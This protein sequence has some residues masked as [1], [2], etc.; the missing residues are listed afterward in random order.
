MDDIKSMDGKTANASDRTSSI[1][2]SVDKMNAMSIVSVKNNWC[3]ATEFIK[4]KPNEIPSGPELLKKIN[5]E[6]CI[7]TFDSMSTQENTINHIAA[8]HAFYVARVKGN[9]PSLEESI[10]EYFN[11]RKLLFSD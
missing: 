5:I 9:Q 2:G 7:V 10:K 4:D 11:D 1:N 3:E 6:N 8:K